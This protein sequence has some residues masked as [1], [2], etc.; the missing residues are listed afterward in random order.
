MRVA[1]TDTQGP[2]IP[3][4]E[5]RQRAMSGFVILPQP[6]SVLMPMAHGTTRGHER[7]GTYSLGI[8]ELAGLIPRWPPQR[9]N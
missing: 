6:E 4:P 7:T 1:Y 8:R 9:E 5:L 2:V 3:R